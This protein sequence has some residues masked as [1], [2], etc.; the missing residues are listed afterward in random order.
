M[1]RTAEEALV[2]CAETDFELIFMDARMPKLDGIATTRLRADGN[3][4][5]IIGVSADAM[6]EERQA[7]LDVGMNDYVVKPVAREAL[8]EAIQRWRQIRDCRPPRRPGQRRK[9]KKARP[10]D[11]IPA[12]A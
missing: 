7:A 12:A 8:A 6:S 3:K 1:P 10:E 5:Y 11:T 4:A 9:L 2:R